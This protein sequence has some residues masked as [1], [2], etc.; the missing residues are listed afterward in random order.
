MSDKD[1]APKE[2][3]FE[4]DGSITIEAE[5]DEWCCKCG[6]GDKQTFHGSGFKAEIACLGFCAG[7]GSK[8]HSLKK[9]RC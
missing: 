1:E 2:I 9:G 6:S 3:Q 5:G 4:T 8:S 7:K